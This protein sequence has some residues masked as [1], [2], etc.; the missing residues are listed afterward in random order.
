M[1]IASQ[2]TSLTIVYS[3]VYSGAHQRKHQ[4]S[5]S[6]AIVSGIHRSPVN[7]PH[8]GSVTREMF[9]FHDVIMIIVFR[10]DTDSTWTEQPLVSSSSG[11]H[12][13]SPSTCPRVNPTK[14]TASLPHISAPI[15]KRS[16]V[17]AQTPTGRRMERA[18]IRG[19]PFGALLFNPSIGSSGLTM[20]TV[21]DI[22][23]NVLRDFTGSRRLCR[24]NVWKR[25]RIQVLY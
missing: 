3:T 21:R 22:A 16:S 13:F 20:P 14:F 15:R 12:L 17:T 8:K 10:H 5:A 2:I 18:I 25:K 11:Y 7:S 4:S 9:P 24:K 19:T 6:L 23:S 1:A